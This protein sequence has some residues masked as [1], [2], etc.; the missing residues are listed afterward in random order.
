MSALLAFDCPHCQHKF[1]MAESDIACGIV[2]HGAINDE[3]INP[4]A[5][6]EQCEKYLTMPNVR[7][8]CKPVKI[9][10]KDDT[11]IAEVCDYI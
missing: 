9:T 11:Y 2:R 5:S 3:P 8:C 6:K 10:K 4:H 7:G 1:V